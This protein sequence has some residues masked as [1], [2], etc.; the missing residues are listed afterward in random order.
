MYPTFPYPTLPI[1]LKQ[2]K[3][4]RSNNQHF[5][6]N[7]TYLRAR[8]IGFSGANVFDALICPGNN[9]AAFSL[10]EPFFQ[11]EALNKLKTVTEILKQPTPKT[12]VCT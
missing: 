9:E 6:L 10:N 11:Y 3:I 5:S 7:F 1:A 4:F 8:S 2:D 12:Q